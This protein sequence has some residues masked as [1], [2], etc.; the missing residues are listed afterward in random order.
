MN[1]LPGTRAGRYYMQYA[2]PGTQYKSYGDGVFVADSVMGPW[3][4][5]APGLVGIRGL[6][7]TR[8]RTLN[9]ILL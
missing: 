3:A 5:G 7:R 9:P 8:Y 4:R 2:A 1:V 6:D